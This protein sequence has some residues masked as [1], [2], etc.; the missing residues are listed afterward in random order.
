MRKGGRGR[1][2]GKGGAR[3]WRRGEE[4]GDTPPESSC[5]EGDNNDEAVKRL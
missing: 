5:P 3:G 2:K 4:A 1:G